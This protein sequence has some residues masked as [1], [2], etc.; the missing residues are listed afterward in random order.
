[1]IR[2][3]CGG[4]LVGTVALALRSETGKLKIWKLRGRGSW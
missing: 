1:M 4:G 2:W 3:E